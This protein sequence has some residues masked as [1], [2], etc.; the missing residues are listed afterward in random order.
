MARFEARRYQIGRYLSFD[1][2]HIYS[3]VNTG[4]WSIRRAAC[5]DR[6]T[7]IRNPDLKDNIDTANGN[8]TVCNEIRV[9]EQDR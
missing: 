3:N 5:T 6:V 8:D 4:E 7:I 1:K 2:I 9:S